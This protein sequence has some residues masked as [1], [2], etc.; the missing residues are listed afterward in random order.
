[1]RSQVRRGF[2]LIEL[3]VVL[4][5]I[6][7]VVGGVMVG[8]DL[9]RAAGVRSQISQIEK[10]QAAANTFK[11]KY[12]YL[13]GDIPAPDASRFGFLARGTQDG[14]GDGNGQL[15]GYIL[16]G[17][18]YL[19]LYLTCGETGLFWRDLSQVAL[20]DGG[21]SRAT[22]DSS[23]CTPAITGTAMAQYLPAAKIGSDNFVYVW[24][25]GWEARN[26]MA[27]NPT[28]YFGLSRVSSSNF[29]TGVGLTVREAYE[30]DV[31]TDD[32]LPQAGAVMAMYANGEAYSPDDESTGS[33]WAFG[34]S[35]TSIGGSCAI[36]GNYS[37]GPI[38]PGLFTPVGVSPSETTCYDTGGSFSA[39]AQYSIAFNNGTGM[40][41]A[42]SFRFR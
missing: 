16:N 5:I 36:N 38:L 3:S 30:I 9:V 39:K 42:L 6:G 41:C 24:S 27:E 22:A 11:A 2:T 4:V 37:G 29:H 8:R 7:L 19:G 14:Q 10:Y 40:N 34:G 31:K 12:G 17:A 23:A 25:G 26:S 28:N 35:N 1:M 32:G 13:P 33:V 15:H 20:V 18:P 21:F